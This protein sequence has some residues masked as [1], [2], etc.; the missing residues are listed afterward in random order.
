[1]DGAHDEDRVFGK[2]LIG[3]AG[4]TLTGRSRVAAMIGAAGRPQGITVRELEGAILDEFN[5][6]HAQPDAVQERPS[7]PRVS[8]IEHLRA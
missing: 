3:K 4:Q 2:V 6:G 1:M 5:R 8:T 7:V